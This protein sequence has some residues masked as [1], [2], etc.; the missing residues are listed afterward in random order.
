MLEQVV[1]VCK[2]L[3]LLAV[4]QIFLWSFHLFTISLPKFTTFSGIILPGFPLHFLLSLPNV[5]YFGFDFFLHPN[6][7]SDY[8]CP[9]CD[10][11]SCL[12]SSFGVLSEN[13]VR[14]VQY[15]IPFHTFTLNF[16][17]ALSF[18]DQRKNPGPYHQPGISSLLINCNVEFCFKD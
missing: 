7:W 2:P 5:V 8:K 10:T 18:S 4:V 9:Y 16:F 13:R 11:H 3:T 14:P 17:F 1:I 12:E 15:F 6:Y